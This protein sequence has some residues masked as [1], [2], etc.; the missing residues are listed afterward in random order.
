MA[1]FKDVESM[2]AKDKQAFI[3]GW[4]RFLKSGMKR[5]LFT[6]RIYTHLYLHCG[7]IAHYNLEQFYEVRIQDPKGRRETFFQLLNY[8][9]AQDYRDVHSEMGVIIQKYIKDILK[10]TDEQEI[11]E[12]Q[13]ERSSIG[14]RLA[15]LIKE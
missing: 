4:E 9:P 11:E 12:I 1:K 2:S 5:T 6:D 7:F 3:K 15:E 8:L 14:R 13:Q 10:Q